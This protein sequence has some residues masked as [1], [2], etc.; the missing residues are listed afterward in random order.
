M[1][2]WN[3]LESIKRA[4]LQRSLWLTGKKEPY[5]I[6]SENTLGTDPNT[7]PTKESVNAHADGEGWYLKDK[8]TPVT[9]TGVYSFND[10]G[11]LSVEIEYQ[12][13]HFTDVEK[14]WKDIND[15][16]YIIREKDTK[17]GNKEEGS[18]EEDKEGNVCSVP[19]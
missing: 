10:Y 6:P 4:R 13:R 3:I 11:M 8:K 9:F 7:I 5:T 12:F 18:K 16:T 2:L 17:D 19:F 1:S 15:L 14:H